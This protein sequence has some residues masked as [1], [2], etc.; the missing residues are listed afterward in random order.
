VAVGVWFVFQLVAGLNL[1]G[2]SGETGV[3]YAAHIAG[4]IAGAALAIP[5]TLGRDP[6]TG[7]DSYRF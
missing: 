6:Q 1:L 7:S 2:G 5:F 4:F 3:A